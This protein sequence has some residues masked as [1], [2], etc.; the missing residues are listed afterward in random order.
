MFKNNKPTLNIDGKITFYI[1]HAIS[2]QLHYY[3]PKI[4]FQ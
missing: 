3:H 4:T 1:S 2:Q